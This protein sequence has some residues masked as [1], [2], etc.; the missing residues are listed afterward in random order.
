MHTPNN[1]IKCP[2]LVNYWINNSTID[3][4]VIKKNIH[5]N[6]SSSIDNKS[7]LKNVKYKNK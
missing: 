7:N 6:K 4:V 1:T 2:H 3:A 5:S